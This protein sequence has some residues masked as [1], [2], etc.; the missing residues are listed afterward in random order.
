M[1]LMLTIPF[2]LMS[3]T[4]ARD[5]DSQAM[6]EQSSRHPLQ[7]KLAE[8]DFS[9]PMTREEITQLWGEPG[10][11]GPGKV[12]DAYIIENYNEL[13]LS[14]SDRPP[15]I[16]QRAVL[17]DSKE[18]KFKNLFNNIAKTKNRKCF[19]LNNVK[20]L[21]QIMVY[22]KWGPPDSVFGSGIDNWV[23]ELK[24][25]GVATIIFDNTGSVRIL[26]GC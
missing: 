22:K 25:G 16:L 6:M 13:W 14:F 9:S 23:Y 26:T 7:R 12:I 4:L 5:M 2:V 11:I 1:R 17:I 24:C 15:F 18:N 21:D 19:D 10:K 8:I 3:P 20:S